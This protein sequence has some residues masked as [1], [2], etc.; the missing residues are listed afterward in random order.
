M[1]GGETKIPIVAASMNA[2]SATSELHA[3]NYE[4][5]DGRR[6]R[7]ATRDEW[8]RNKERGTLDKRTFS[9]RPS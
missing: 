5:A 3:G 9:V 2:T 7:H 6:W 8:E 1:A 4:T